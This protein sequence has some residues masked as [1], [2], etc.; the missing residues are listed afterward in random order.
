MY[1]KGAGRLGLIV[2]IAM[3][4]E[5]AW[6]DYRRFQVDSKVVPLAR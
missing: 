4:E 6:S 2:K 3:D 1:M 5:I